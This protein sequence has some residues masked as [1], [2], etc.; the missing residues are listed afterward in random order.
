MYE[1]S[2]TRVGMIIHNA[3]PVDVNL[4]LAAFE[5]QLAGLLNLVRFA[6]ESGLSQGPQFVSVSSIAAVGGLAAEG[7]PVPEDV[8]TSSITPSSFQWWIWPK[9]MSCQLRSNRWVPILCRSGN[10]NRRLW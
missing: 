9:Q 5:P 8:F 6:A 10:I 1:D 2:R 7:G 3:W 4:W